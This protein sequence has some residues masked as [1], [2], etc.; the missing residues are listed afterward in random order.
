MISVG[1]NVKKFNK[2]RS[3]SNIIRDKQRLAARPGKR[4]SAEGNT[5]YEKRAN[6]SDVS[7]K[8]RL[9]HGG[10]IPWN[11]RTKEEREK[12]QSEGLQAKRDL[13]AHLHKES[14]LKAGD[15]VTW[16]NK[17][18]VFEVKSA[19]ENVATIVKIGHLSDDE[20][21]GSYQAI[22]SALT[23]VQKHEKGGS[24][25]KKGGKVSKF[26]QT[27]REFKA[28]TL[29]SSSGDTVTTKNQALAI[30]F[31]ESRKEKMQTSS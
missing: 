29:K 14:D 7:K 12:L 30:A 20:Y 21:K 16:K 26:A 6:R 11:E 28:G 27:M 17:K 3:A 31:A 18:G 1:A 22:T 15:I 5:Y 2:G 23:M 19:N 4:T 25:Y 24:L 10:N 8:D 13:E 9:K